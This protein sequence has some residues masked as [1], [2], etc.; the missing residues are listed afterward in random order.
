MADRI[1]Q[2]LAVVLRAVDLGDFE[3]APPETTGVKRLLD[4]LCAAAPSDAA[5]L[6]QGFVLLDA[7]AAS[8]Q[9]QTKG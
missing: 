8:Y 9:L 3:A 7:L 5:R 1:P 2:R 6:E 4:G